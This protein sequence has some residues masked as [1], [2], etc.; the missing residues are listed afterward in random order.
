LQ[1]SLGDGQAAELEGLQAQGSS[2]GA[3]DN[4][5]GVGSE[6]FVRRDC[7]RHAVGMKGQDRQYGFCSSLPRDGVVWKGGKRVGRGGNSDHG[8]SIMRNGS[9]PKIH[10]LIG[11][12]S[13]V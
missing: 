5:A 1:L 3:T 10:R 7:P 2:T 8:C 4:I 6:E 13:A 11:S 9:S 12:A